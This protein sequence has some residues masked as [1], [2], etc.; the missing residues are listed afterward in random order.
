[1]PPAVAAGSFT[2]AAARQRRGREQVAQHALAAEIPALAS[3][4]TISAAMPT[5]S[6]PP[7]GWTGPVARSRARSR[8]PGVAPVSGLGRMRLGP[9]GRA[10]W[11]ARLRAVLAR[12]GVAGFAA[13]AVAA[14]REARRVL[15]VAAAPGAAVA[16]PLA[17]SGRRSRVALA[18]WPASGAALRAATRRRSPA[19]GGCAAG[20]RAR[21][22]RRVRA[23]VSVALGSGR[24][25]SRLARR[26][27]CWPPRSAPAAAASGLAHCAIRPRRQRRAAW[28]CDVGAY[29]PFWRQTR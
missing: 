7:G 18:A 14:W 5:S 4:P 23:R 12:G 28:A 10:A 2:E 6:V 1:M 15:R 24:G 16:L 17:P 11:P 19:A 8:S 25:R 9:A 26:H 3:S 29:R 22:P 21:P 27:H 20:S 13:A